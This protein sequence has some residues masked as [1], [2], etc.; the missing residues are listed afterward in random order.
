[1]HNFGIIFLHPWLLL[2]IIPAIALTLIPY[3]L[4]NK[5]YRRTRNRIISMVL[6]SIVMVLVIF[7]LAGI[8]FTYQVNNLENEVIVLVDVS[9]TQEDVAERRD[10]FVERVLSE[11][12]YDG[13]KMG[14]VLFGFTQK[15]AVELSFET[16]LL[17]DRYQEAL[18]GVLPDTTATDIAAALEYTASL[19]NYP[20][21]AKIVLVTDGAETDENAL[22]AVRSVTARGIRIDTVYLAGGLMGDSVRVTNIIFPE[23]HI[24][25]NQEATL[26]VQVESLAASSGSSCDVV[27]SDNGE[28]IARQQLAITGGIQLVPF[29]HTFTEGGLHEITATID[30]RGDLIPQNNSYRACLHVESFT[31]IAILESAT[32]ASQP[33]SELLA[34]EETVEYDVKQ[35]LINEDSAPHTVD[36]L[37]AYDQIIL[38]NIAPS[39]MPEGFDEALYSYVYDY[40]GGVFTAGGD[41]AAGSPHGYNRAEMAGDTV[42]DD[43]LP[44]EVINYTPPLGVMIIV[45]V[46]GSMSSVQ[47]DGKSKLAWA[48]EGAAQCLDILTE[49]DFVGLMTLGSTYGFVLPL[50]RRTQEDAIRDAIRNIDGNGGTEFA[51][52]V[53][54]AGFAL[55]S[56]DRVDK[57]HII[58]VTDGEPA[59]DDAFLE[60]VDTY[61]QSGITFSLLVI[62]PENQLC[63]DFKAHG[64]H[65]YVANSAFECVSQMTEDLQ[66]KAVEESKTEELHPLIA[67]TLSPVVAGVNYGG[68]EGM[69]DRAMQATLGGFYGTKIKSDAKVILQGEYDVPIYAQ[70]KFGK[71]S[72]GS[73]LCDIGGKWSGGFL[74]D[75]DGRRLLLNAIANLMPLENIR[76]QNIDYKFQEENYINELS[77]SPRKA[78]ESG[79]KLWGQIVYTD[80]ETKEEVSVPLDG[81]K[82]RADCYIKLPLDSTSGYSRCDFVVTLP[83]LYHILI[84]RVDAGGN[85]VENS[86]LEFYKVF[87]YSKEYGE[88]TVEG[89]EVQ[90]P[91]VFLSTLALRGGGNTV[92][93]EE[94]WNVFLDFVTDLD[95]TFDPRWILLIV[96]MVLFLLD[97]IVRKFKFKWIHEIVRER[98][99]QKEKAGANGRGGKQGG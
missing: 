36:D 87:S 5:R 58:I 34:S 62:G 44:V 38:N 32:G 59:D 24:D 15:E 6:H 90:D 13:F 72:V 89:V 60:C 74:A 94:P 73:F 9:D 8:T 61:T 16:E 39:D 71:G 92:S 77:V 29:T 41:D 11:G 51:P 28:E 14:V 85:V 79:E 57:R 46:S 95:R 91:Q 4:L 99:E 82:N 52:A 86:T 12:G 76:V 19:F 21:S 1:M 84:E 10:E 53:E 54:R 43:I 68:V 3:F 98:K 35:F 33:I 81:S 83:G 70:W 49:R 96:A 55:N 63:T 20:A 65:V 2:L 64:G 7:V 25:I 66:A 17:Y 50:T 42:Y 23:T 31:K 27:F 69:S 75:A 56:E 45:D 40:G 93:I 78:L 88:A 37:R 30:S 22:D 67:D 18:A 26:M 48:K 80:P 47:P 97:I